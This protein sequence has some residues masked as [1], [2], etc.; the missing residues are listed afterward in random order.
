MRRVL[1]AVLFVAFVCAP[2]HATPEDWRRPVE[3]RVVR[4]F[5]APTTRYG[6][7]HFGVHL[8]A[9][10]GTPVR[11]ANGG[12]VTFAGSVAHVNFVVVLHA[13]GLR[14]TYGYLTRPL[15]HAGDHVIRG[16]V[17]GT[18]VGTVAHFGLR[19]GDTY[20]DPMQLFTPP[21]LGDRVHLAPLNAA[22]GT[23]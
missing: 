16:Q 17:V 19:E 4:P 12:R 18:T 14:T 21:D 3:G 9:A 23:G 1:L 7:G 5:K 8:A 2:A 6:P 13:G 11:A 20:V 15:V 22:K 10:P